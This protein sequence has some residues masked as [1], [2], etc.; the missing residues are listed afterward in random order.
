MHKGA[1][2]HFARLCAILRFLQA[3]WQEKTHGN[4][5]KSE[6][7]RKYAQ[8][9]ATLNGRMQNPAYI[10]IYAVELKAGP[11]FAFSSVKSWS[12]FLVLFVFLFLKISFSL[13]KEEDFSKNERRKINKKNNISSVKN[14]SNFV[15]QHTWTSF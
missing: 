5:Q 9:R 3:I 15:A 8:K 11:I 2:A 10:Y 7:K 1:F 13:Q 14:W 12:I 4:A 6:K